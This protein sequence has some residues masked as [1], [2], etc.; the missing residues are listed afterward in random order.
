MA[1]DRRITSL[2]LLTL[3]ASF[4]DAAL[5]VDHFYTLGNEAEGYTTMTR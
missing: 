3:L 2:I 5:S 4:P 1:V